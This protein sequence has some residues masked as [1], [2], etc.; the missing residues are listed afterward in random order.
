MYTL[1]SLNIG[2]C[3]IEETFGVHGLSD[4]MSGRNEIFVPTNFRPQSAHTEFHFKLSKSNENKSVKNSQD[5]L[6]L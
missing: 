5:Q 3:T 1:L 4:I 6:G 2:K